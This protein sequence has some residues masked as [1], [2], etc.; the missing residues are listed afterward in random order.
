MPPSSSAPDLA[1]VVAAWDGHEDLQAVLDL[2]VAD[3]EARDED[4]CTAFLWACNKG[5]VSA[6]RTLS[7]MP[8]S[9]R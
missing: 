6:T 3:R 2:G 9:R 5:S 7:Q 8:E 4:G 1:L